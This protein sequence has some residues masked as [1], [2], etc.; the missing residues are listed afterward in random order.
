MLLHP[1]AIRIA[2]SAGSVGL[3]HRE[4]FFVLHQAGVGESTQVDASTA[5]PAVREPADFPG[6]Q[7]P[8][9][10]DEYDRLVHTELADVARVEQRPPAFG[11]ALA[12]AEPRG[13]CCVVVLVLTSTPW[14]TALEM[15]AMKSVSDE[16]KQVTMWQL[17]RIT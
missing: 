1:A 11:F 3:V 2:G 8:G 4:D 6:A 13:P 7:R 10:G 9:A 14:P 17:S 12:A 15:S 5:K 16:A